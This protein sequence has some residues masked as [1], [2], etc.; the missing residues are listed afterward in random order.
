MKKNC[1]NSC[2]FCMIQAETVKHMFYE[3]LYVANLWRELFT[4][5]N[6]FHVLT[7]DE[8]TILLGYDISRDREDHCDGNRLLLYTKQYIRQCKIGQKIPD[9]RD[10]IAW[11]KTKSAID[12]KL[13][14]IY[15]LKKVL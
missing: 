5:V 4:F 2:T 15:I 12:H 11:L 9:I 13:P 8:K 7:L 14:Y 10:C 1:T 3:C 6:E